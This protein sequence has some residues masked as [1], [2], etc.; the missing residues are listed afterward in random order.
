MRL[1]AL[2]HFVPRFQTTVLP[3]YRGGVENI[4]GWAKASGGQHDGWVLQVQQRG[5]EVHAD[6]HQTFKLYY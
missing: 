4:R 2:S 3:G 1:H 6:S 5:E